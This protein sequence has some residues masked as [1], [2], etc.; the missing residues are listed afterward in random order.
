MIRARSAEGF[1][2]TS[3]VKGL[4]SL[5]VH[6]KY[7]RNLEVE[8]FLK[9]LI[10]ALII[11]F[12]VLIGT[13]VTI[14]LNNEYTRV[15]GDA[16]T[17][18]SL[19]ADLV[20]ARLQMPDAD[21]APDE[22][23][24]SSGAG[25]L[26]AALQNITPAPGQIFLLTDGGGI[27][28]SATAQ[29]Y[30]WEGRQLA[31]ILS[32][33]QPLVDLAAR[34]GVLE[35]DIRESST[36]L[37]TVRKIGMGPIQLAALQDMELS[38]APWKQN[39]AFSISLFTSTGFVLILLGGAFFWQAAR[40]TEADRIYE[41]TRTRLDIALERG[42]CGLWD[43][44][45]SGGRIFWSKSMF[46]I[47]GL[48]ARDEVTAIDEM[49]ERMHPDDTDLYTIA[50]QLLAGDETCVDHDF[51]MRHAD[52]QWVWLRAR[53]RMMKENGNA[54]AHLVGIAVDISE[55]RS[56]VEKS[57]TANVR[58]RDAIETISE[59]FVLWDTDNKMLLC[60]SKYQE[61]HDL[62]DA[63][64]LP[65]TAYDD[66]INAARHSVVRTRIAV[67]SERERGAR[68]FE[69]QMDGGRW[70]Q[71]NERRTKDGGYVSVGTDITALKQH[72]ERLM[73]G[74]RVLMATVADLRRSRQAL[75]EQA[76]QLI[77]LADKY[78]LEK[79]RAEAANQA[80]SEFLTNIS[81]ELRTPLNAI[82]G[83]SEI[84]ESQV[85]GAIGS[86]KYLEYSKDI[87]S[88][89]EFLRDVINDIL[90]MAK[91]E[92][93]CQ[94]LEPED[95]QVNEIVKESIRI[96]AAKAEEQNL[97]VTHQV[98]DNIWL[99]AD[100]RSI[101]QV[102]LNLLSNAVKFTPPGGKIVVSANQTDD[103]FEF[104]IADTGIGI[105]NKALERLGQPFEQVQNQFT[106]SHSGSGLG[107]AISR[108]LVE[109]HGGKL[110]LE[111]KEHVGTTVIVEIPA[112]SQL[113]I[114]N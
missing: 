108:S 45:V 75:E 7:Q 76:Q 23:S 35:I 8:P 18:L 1:Q 100:R 33:S 81:H 36:V 52:G 111:S 77:D 59:A 72:E 71:T 2:P 65:G 91:I 3:S 27:V 57:K 103:H 13:T 9:K 46:E 96:I 67:S 26:S 94:T 104:R 61:F 88:S 107:L 28:R 37:A 73:E 99:V 105:P 89:G 15:L 80:K 38:L 64:I 90:D 39:V 4:A 83:F 87:K 97:S 29:P 47:L 6:T 109:L 19:V 34:A 74:E 17:S 16:K 66:V 60:N 49:H 110:I 44:D 41:E 69:A 40:A 32:H 42:R 24:N 92:A 25:L 101:K 12:A 5:L 106:K 95:L 10:F 70:L 51:R 113:A 63:A 93:G 112:E 58:L 50:E 102:M 85:F 62:P 21:T 86:S 11:I 31:E 22:N 82:I 56:L 78:S 84:M 68:T 30:I 54:K 20:E 53:G 79:E 114:F 14:R 55:Q 48:E 98:A 43:W